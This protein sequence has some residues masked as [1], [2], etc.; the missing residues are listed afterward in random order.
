MNSAHLYLQQQVLN[1]ICTLCVFY[2]TYTYVLPW[3][4]ARWSVWC[5][6][7]NTISKLNARSEE[8][9][10]ETESLQESLEELLKEAELKKRQHNNIQNCTTE[11][12]TSCG[13]AQGMS[14]LKPLVLPP[15]HAK[16]CDPQHPPVIQP[17]KN[18]AQKSARMSMGNNFRAEAVIPLAE[19]SNP[20]INVSESTNKTD[21]EW[22]QLRIQQDAEYAASLARDQKT[23]AAQVEADLSLELLRKERIALLESISPE[24]VDELLEN[25]LILQFRFHLA[26]SQGVSA[27]QKITRRFLV[28]DTTDSVLAFAKTHDFVPFDQMERVVVTTGVVLVGSSAVLQPG[29][30]LMAFGRGSLVLHVRFKEEE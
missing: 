19:R 12:K 20:W 30:N 2:L 9:R 5:E 25:V 28:S 29:G 17:L 23:A 11:K 7:N 22:R 3:I 4:V 16:K 13:A 14:A 26:P 8:I 6:K 18:T 27:P 1:S 10:R 21:D 15:A 24:P